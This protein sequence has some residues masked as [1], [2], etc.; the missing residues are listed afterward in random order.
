MTLFLVSSDVENT[1]VVDSL[2]MFLLSFMSFV[3]FLIL[4]RSTVTLG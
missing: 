1:F 2:I 4:R 3:L